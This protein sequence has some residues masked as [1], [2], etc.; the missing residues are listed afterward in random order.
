MIK[1]FS[2]KGYNFAAKLR[3]RI[4]INCFIYLF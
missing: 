4:I 2:A 3:I 1:P